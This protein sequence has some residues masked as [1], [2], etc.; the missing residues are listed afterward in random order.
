MKL[1][2]ISL[3]LFQIFAGSLCAMTA[4]EK[5]EFKKQLKAAQTSQEMEQL[6]QEKFKKYIECKK[7]KN[8]DAATTFW[9]PTLGYSD[10]TNKLTVNFCLKFYQDRILITSDIPGFHGTQ[11][12]KD[13]KKIVEEIE[14]II[15]HLFFEELHPLFFEGG[16]IDIELAKFKKYS[17]ANLSIAS[18]LKPIF[19]A[20]L[21]QLNVIG[22]TKESPLVVQRYYFLRE[23]CAQATG[24]DS[25]FGGSEWLSR[26][27]FGYQ[28]AVLGINV[29]QAMLSAG[30]I[31]GALYYLKKL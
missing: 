22:P 2:Y 26:K 11:I 6:V 18:E 1:R 14:Q 20:H 17:W 29:S 28:H 15:E 7:S 27:I 9:H 4:D 8:W 5:A 30:A 31:I 21:T 24:E 12:S 25:L 23:Q 13:M 19:K 16:D 10:Y 3:I